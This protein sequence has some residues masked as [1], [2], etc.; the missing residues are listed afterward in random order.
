MRR[1]SC[2]VALVILCCLGG[3]A[4]PSTAARRGEPGRIRDEAR[5]LSSDE[6]ESLSRQLRRFEEESQVKLGIITL[7]RM[8][9]R[10]PKEV[11][12]RTLERWALGPRSAL[13]LV[14]LSPRRL[15]LQPGSDLARTLNEDTASAICK[16]RIAPALRDSQAYEALSAGLLAIR[17]ALASPRRSAGP[18]ADHP[19]TQGAVTRPATAGQRREAARAEAHPRQSWLPWW[20]WLLLCVAGLGLLVR[21][22]RRR[23]RT[24]TKGVRQRPDH[25]PDTEDEPRKARRSGGLIE[26]VRCLSGLSGMG[27]LGGARA[28]SGNASRGGGGSAW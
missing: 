5:M 27:L 25:A 3:L 10:S 12:A 23:R 14:S 17:E 18:S 20:G 13:L 8:G 7:E 26:L 22:V 19:A 21:A 9:R 1:N 4:R 24:G 11:A 16:L 15:H 2:C 28:R 6:L